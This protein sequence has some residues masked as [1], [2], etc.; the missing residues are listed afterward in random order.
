MVTLAWACLQCVTFLQVRHLQGHC[1]G[2]Q[3]CVAGTD[4]QMLGEASLEQPWAGGGGVRWGVGAVFCRWFDSE[5]LSYKANMES[6][7]GVGVC[8]VDPAEALALTKRPVFPGRCVS[9]HL[10]TE[11]TFNYNLDC[12]GNEKTVCRCG[13]SNCSGFL[14][15][16]PKVKARLPS[17]PADVSIL[18]V[19]E[20][21]P[22]SEK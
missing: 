20:H 16:R 19:Y 1:M 21:D 6:C 8:S 3:G 11:L 2:P 12:L 13:A 18:D 17:S 10:G 9:C 4:H 14:G 5:C 22:F 15:D 7:E